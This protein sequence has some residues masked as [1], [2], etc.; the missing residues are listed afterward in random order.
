MTGPKIL[1]DMMFEPEPPTPRGPQTGI[2]RTNTGG[3]AAI[4]RDRLVDTFVGIG[5]K[6]AAIRAAGTNRVID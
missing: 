4:K 6:A 5:S 2:R 3:W 1:A